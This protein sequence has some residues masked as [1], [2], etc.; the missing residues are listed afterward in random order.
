MISHEECDTL[1]ERVR[2][3]LDDMADELTREGALG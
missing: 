1:V 2:S 3:S